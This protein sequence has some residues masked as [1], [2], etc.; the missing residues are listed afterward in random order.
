M[1]RNGGD[2]IGYVQVKRQNNKCIVKARITPEQRVKK[3]KSYC[4]SIDIEEIISKV[5]C[6]DCAAWE[7]GCKHIIELIM[8]IFATRNNLR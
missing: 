8:S 2:A 7:S 3:S 6:E 1:K 5:E 4:A